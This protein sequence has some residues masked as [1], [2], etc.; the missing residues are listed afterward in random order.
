MGGGGVDPFVGLL[1][2]YPGAAAAYS[3]RQLSSTYTAP[4][5]SEFSFGNALDFDGS[6]D[7]VDVGA[8]LDPALANNFGFSCWFKTTSTSTV[9]NR[10][11][12]PFVG[13]A[14]DQWT[15]AVGLNGGKITTMSYDGGVQQ[16]E[17]SNTFNDG[18]WHCMTMLRTRGATDILATASIWIDG[19]LELDAV[20][21]N[22]ISGGYR[23]ADLGV[24]RPTEYAD[25]TLD[26]MV[27]YQGVGLSIG[28][29]ENLSY[30]NNGNGALATD[31]FSD[32]YAYYRMNESGT[33]ATLTDETGNYNGTLNGF[34]LP[35]AWVNGK[36]NNGA[37]V[38]ILRDSTPAAY[39]VFYSD[40]N[41]E[42]SL[43]SPD[44]NGVTLGTW[45]GSND[46]FVRTWYDQSG[47]GNN[48]TQI[49][50]GSQPQIVS[51]GV[52]DLD[53]L[54]PAIV[55]NGTSTTLTDTF[56]SISQP[57]TIF[58]IANTNAING[59]LM[60]DGIDSVNR[61]TYD[62]NGDA[63]AGASM[64]GTALTVDT[65]YLHSLLYNSSSSSSY[66]N[67]IINATGNVGTQGLTG[68]TVGSRF[69]G[70]YWSGSIQELIIYNSD[71]SSNRTGIETN[72]N[73]YYNIYSPPIGAFSSAFSSAFNLD[74][75]PPVTFMTATGGDD[76]EGTT[77]GDYKYH[78]FNSSGTFTVLSI[79]SGAAESAAV[80]ALIIAGGAGGGGFAGGGAGGYRNPT[81]HTVTAQ[82]YSITVG[83]GG[84]GSASGST[85]GSN[86]S[87]SIFDTYTSTGGGSGGAFSTANATGLDGGSGGGGGTN[88]SSPYAGR[89]GG[90]G[91]TPSTTPSQGNDGGM[92]VNG[93]TAGGGGG[94]HTAAGQNASFNTGG[95][96]G[97]GTS[98]S[99]T[100]SSLSYAGGGGG[101]G[102]ATRGVGVDGGGNGAI[103]G[104]SG[105]TA[106][107]AN[108]GGSGGGGYATPGGNG[109]S[110][111]V[112]IKYKFQ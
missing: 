5:A 63:Y 73:N 93:A 102:G 21:F 55:F 87:D 10:V 89:A 34:T 27:F 3:V 62:V 103:A 99:I 57:N 41:N 43:T 45:I 24:S 31:V 97:T 20:N 40:A 32:I 79:G 17:G 38:E 36:A 51:G 74:Y 92:G 94:G 110:G 66:R 70:N 16:N 65:Q 4:T 109:G 22:I 67:S 111:I 88:S 39:N 52:V 12:T 91:N 6:N 75:I 96:G 2:A 25:V 28:L 13:F 37:L 58:S 59:G 108:T 11:A 106:G 8:N 56:D 112:I 60:Y 80:D 81:G 107:T 53:N 101:G 64:S 104:G 15:S 95:N 86:G 72:I 83:A 14:S 46:G 18:E 19:V 23:W 90:G 85:K 100:G 61:S 105:V 35:G 48:A 54:K 1:D 68:I 33:D 77:D 82:G 9:A 76:F 30:Y 71:Q 29:S 98:N 50:V 26:E 49:T 84:S 78:T 69:S 47:N 42:L 7:Y 44:A